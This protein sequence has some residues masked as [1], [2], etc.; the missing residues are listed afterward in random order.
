M[1]SDQIVF[2]LQHVK[3]AYICNIPATQTD[4]SQLSIIT[5]PLFFHYIRTK[6]IHPQNMNL[7]AYINTKLVYIDNRFKASV[8]TLYTDL[9]QK[10]CELEHKVLLH[11]LTLA[12][13]SLFEF[14]YSMGRRF[15]G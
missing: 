15:I 12:T 11:K 14:A 3:L 13:Y 6:N 4:H 2:A 8:S 1:K 7:M 9:I 5:D 10:Q